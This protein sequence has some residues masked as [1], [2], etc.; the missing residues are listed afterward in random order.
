M[1]VLTKHGR[2]ETQKSSSMSLM[3]VTTIASHPNV[4]GGSFSTGEDGSYI[5]RF[6]G[7][8]LAVWMRGFC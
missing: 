7:T 6:E 4:F 5:W 1:S 2:K 3:F 8:G